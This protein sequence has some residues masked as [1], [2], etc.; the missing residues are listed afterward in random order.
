MQRSYASL[1][2]QTRHTVMGGLWNFLFRSEMLLKLPPT[3]CF[4]TSVNEVKSDHVH[5]AM[6]ILTIQTSI[7][8]QF[9][10]VA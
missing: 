3:W 4:S 6:L 9:H 8:A 2:C 5:K 7:K 10:M 1:Q